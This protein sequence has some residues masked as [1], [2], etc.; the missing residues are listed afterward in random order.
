[1]LKYPILNNL[2]AMSYHLPVSVKMMYSVSGEGR[3]LASQ[4]AV[5]PFEVSQKTFLP[6]IIDSGSAL[7]SMTATFSDRTW[8][9]SA[10]RGL[11]D[12]SMSSL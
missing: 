2:S 7:V 8:N 5:V 12:F 10:E 6:L 4:P 11:L 9:S 1:M 3:M